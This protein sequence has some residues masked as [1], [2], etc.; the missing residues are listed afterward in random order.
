MGRNSGIYSDDEYY[1]ILP[2]FI[3]WRTDSIKYS[4]PMQS[5]S[6][7]F[8]YIF[9][10]IIEKKE[11][12][13]KREVQRAVELLVQQSAGAPIA[14]CISGGV[15]SEIIARTL[16]ENAIDFELFFLSNWG[17]N[18]S[19]LVDFVKPLAQELGAKLHIIDLE[20]DFFREQYVPESFFKY[21]CH[22][23][24]YIALTYLFSK[25]PKNYFIVVGE[26][27]LEKKGVAYEKLYIKSNSLLCLDKNSIPIMINEIFYRIW[28][29][30]NQRKGQFY[31]YNSTPELV[32]SMWTRSDYKK[33]FPFFG[34]KAAIA[35]MYPEL[36][37]RVKS[38]N[39]EEDS[40]NNR[41]E[42]LNYL[43]NLK[44]Q[45]T[46]FD[47][48]DKHMGCFAVVDDIFIENK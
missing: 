25:I 43:W 3:E 33:A 9:K 37:P 39:W 36:K 24:T 44:S 35:N 19:V 14:V 46:E 38:T 10:P 6:C 22:F 1:D 28:A 16:K 23:P 48:W 21:G 18:N 27:D 5:R 8:K 11:Y 41:K 7:N 15:D 26:G 20:Y 45:R 17:L 34:T 32:A 13:F 12:H 29:Q 2:Q 30:D 31:F 40:Q 4:S 42:I 47:F